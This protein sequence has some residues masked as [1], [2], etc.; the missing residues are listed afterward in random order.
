MM[1]DLIQIKRLARF[2]KDFSL[3]GVNVCLI[4]NIIGSGIGRY[5]GLAESVGVYLR[6]G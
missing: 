2:F 3:V 1:N 4:H 5:I 6:N